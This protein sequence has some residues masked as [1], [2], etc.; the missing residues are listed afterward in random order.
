[1]NEKI[2]FGTDGWRAIIAKEYTLDNL[3]RV[4]EAS[5]QWIVNNSDKPSAV[6]GHDC[7]FGGEMFA[8]ATAVIFAQKG[9]KVYLAKNFVSTPM[10]SLGTH[11]RNAF[12]GIVITASHNPPSYNGF[13]IKAHYGGPATPAMIDEVEALIPEVKEIPTETVAHYVE[14]GL[15]E[16]VNL[17]DEYVEQMEKSFDLNVIRD[18]GLNIAYDAMYGA[19]QNVMRRLFPEATFLHCEDNPGFDGQAPEPVH[20]NLTE[21]SETIR[22]AGD[23]DFGLATDGDADRIGLYNGKG[24]FVDSHH[25]ILL[26]INYLVNHKNL[27]GK[28]AV[29]FS[30]T[31]KIKD[32]CEK[33]GLEAIITKIGFK[34]ICEYMVEDDVLVGGEESGGIAIKGHVPER[35]GI[36]IGVTLLEYMAKTGKTLD[37]LIEEV[38]ALIGTFAMERVDHRISEEKKQEVLALCKGGKI[39]SVGGIAVEKVEDIDGWKLHIGNSE[40]LMIRA[41]GTEPVLR[42]YCQAPTSERA[43][44]LLNML[45]DDIIK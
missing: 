15:I 25:I 39:T 9:I 36:W 21:M 27:K 22:L 13:K 32:L 28:V 42:T 29:S 14:K 4:A 30:C 20:K 43:F 33:L 35:D 19:G 44:K 12:A 37:E 34:Y 41:S 26:L 10:I 11:S 5:A 38:Y 24:D 8:E 18:S 23:I 3:A 7:R 45:A 16:Y 2:K 6:L 40:W 17:E 31:D 1:M